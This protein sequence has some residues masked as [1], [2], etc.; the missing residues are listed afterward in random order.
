MHKKFLQT[1]TFTAVL[2]LSAH[3][4]VTQHAV[5]MEEEHEKW[6]FYVQYNRK[7]EHVDAWIGGNWS[8]GAA[9]KNAEGFVLPLQ[10]LPM[11][12]TNETKYIKLLR[13][14]KVKTLLENK[15]LWENNAKAMYKEA[16]YE[17][18]L[19][20][21]SGIFAA[22]QRSS[23]TEDLS[24]IEKYLEQNDFAWKVSNSD[25]NIE[26]SVVEGWYEN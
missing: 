11:G 25:D 19:G 8:R 6:T 18:L 9:L 5:S 3:L 12:D 1:L 22:K 7:V 17:L 23:T 15:N 21:D 26:I 20:V 10:K 24:Y 14:T 2:F 16:T 13:P 4:L